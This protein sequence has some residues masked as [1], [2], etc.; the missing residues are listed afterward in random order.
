MKDNNILEIETME[1]I[2]IG[3][4]DFYDSLKKQDIPRIHVDWKPPAGGDTRLIEIID[5]LKEIG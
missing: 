3:L 5:K 2:N 1:I 4:M